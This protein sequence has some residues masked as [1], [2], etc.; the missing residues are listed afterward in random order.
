MPQSFLAL[1]VIFHFDKIGNFLLQIRYL[2]IEN[3]QHYRVDYV[4]LT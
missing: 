2:Q 4:Q 1:T 3:K